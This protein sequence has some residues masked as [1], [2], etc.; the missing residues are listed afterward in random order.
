MASILSSPSSSTRSLSARQMPVMA[1]VCKAV[2]HNR[3]LVLVASL[4]LQ[5]CAGVG[6]AF[7]SFS[8]LVKQE[9]GYSQQQITILGIAKDLGASIGL[10]AGSLSGIIPVWCLVAVGAL[11]NLI[12]YGWL[13]LIVTDRASVL[14][15]WAVCI[16]IFVGTNGETY[17]NTAT[18]V[19]N[20]RNFP[21]SRGHVVG[22]LKGFCGLCSA[23]FTQIYVTFF[24]PDEGAYL[25]IVAIGPAIVAF[26]VMLVI[27][28]IRAK[29]RTE[30]TQSESWG[31]AFIYGDCGILAVY[32]MGVL[33]LQDIMA[34]NYD[35][36]LMIAL[37]LLVLVAVPLLTP[38]VAWVAREKMVTSRNDEIIQHITNV[39]VTMDKQYDR[40]LTEPLLRASEKSDIKDAHLNQE[41][42]DPEKTG[43][44]FTSSDLGNPQFG[45]ESRAGSF[46][47]SVGMSELEDEKPADIDLLSEREREGIIVQIRRRILHAAADG[48]VRVKRKRGPHRGEDFTLWQAI[49]KA[50]FWL[51]FFVLLCGAG[52]GM[53]A[54]DNMGQISESQG[55]PNSNVFVSMTSIFNFAGRLLGGYFSEML[56]R[57]YGLPRS[58]ALGVAE[59]CMA[60]GDFLIAMGWPN[61]LYAGTLLVGMGYGAHWGIIPP[62]ISELF[63]MKNFG[64]LYNFYTMATPAGVLFFSGF[65]AGYLYDVEAAKQHIG[66]F[67]TAGLQNSTHI[68]SYYHL[69]TSTNCTGAICFRSAF[70]VMM[71]VCIFGM[72]LTTILSIRTQKVYK[73]LYYKVTLS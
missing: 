53:A 71:G 61:T 27:R 54:I 58:W 45:P 34:V 43:I 23:I 49:L 39:P 30:Q 31:F 10:M 37:I 1:S 36:K 72:I 3:W 24:S 20:V 70:L 38:L 41:V 73:N 46:S 21:K 69:R 28:P 32:L 15:I 47:G 2:W 16:L 35:L 57:N 52:T 14:P 63:G 5:A 42:H 11:H 48:A 64:M 55:Y 12:G 8:P 6:Y 51:L 9:L 4:W 19:T 33:I 50:D 62:I 22:I 66:A 65:L 13:W 68:F 29:Q 26:M 18:L 67:T 56:A 44:G 17:F 25:A 40:R 59:G 7:G 60:A